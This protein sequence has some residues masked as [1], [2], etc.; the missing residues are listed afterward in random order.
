MSR[1]DFAKAKRV[2]IKIGSA[3]LT[4]GGKGLNQ[5]AIAVWVEQMVALKQQGIEVV[6]VSSGAV[7]EGMVRL[8]LTKRPELLHELQAAA[9]VGQMGL[10]QTFESKFQRHG[11]HAAQ[12]LLTHA[13]LADRQRYLNA[14]STLLA[15]LSFNTIP[16]INENDAVATDEIR[17]GDNDTLGALVANLI[18][19]DL[20]IILTDQLGLFSADPSIDKQAVL[21]SEISANDARLELMAGESRSGLGRG[22]MATKVS[23]A[24]LA[25]RSGASTV[26]ASGDVQ[27]VITRIMASESIGS[28]LYSELEPIAARKQWLLVG[29]QA[30][31][32]LQLQADAVVN[33][34]SIERSL[35]ATDIALVEGVFGRGELVVCLDDN[36]VEC[37]RGLVNYKS[38]EIDLIKGYKSEHFTDIL[39]YAD[40]EELIHW[41][42]LVLI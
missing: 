39:G 37:A 4:E 24:K 18:E 25:S 6:L 3:L 28:Y 19:A 5:V 14:R 31:G 35:F 34:Q 2:V 20:L 42:N 30:K 1:N 26:I 9:S 13:D 16:I 10:V 38:T 22:G 17:F 11:L 33:L 41:D 36:G 29:L 23:A 32:Y 21:I 40:D 15:L 8:G 12:V 7:A 27:S